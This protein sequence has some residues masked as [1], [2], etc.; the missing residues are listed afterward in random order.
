MVKKMNAA[1]TARTLSSL[2]GAGVEIVEALTITTGVV[3][4]P[5]FRRVLEKSREEIQKGN[6]ISAVFIENSKLYPLVLGEMI[7]VGEETGKL[8]EMLERLAGFFEE[9]VAEETKSLATIV[10]PV[11]M[12]VIGVAVGFFALAMIQPLYSIVGGL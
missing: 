10:E 11:L 6:P 2:I 12:I 4:N 9:E 8:S 3:Q 5:R 7:A 1:R